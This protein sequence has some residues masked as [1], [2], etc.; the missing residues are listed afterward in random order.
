MVQRGGHTG[1]YRVETSEVGR[2]IVKRKLGH[3]QLT[4]LLGHGGMSAVYEATDLRMGRRV[5]VKVLTCAPGS[6]K[7]EREALYA[8][9]IREA[10]AVAAMSH[11]NIV[12]IHDI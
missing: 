5:A 8:R 1:T 7:E 11:P 2:V 6:T 12:T 9:Q 4:R 3:Y 10:H